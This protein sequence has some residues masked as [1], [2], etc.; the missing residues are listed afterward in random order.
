MSC[1]LSEVDT[2]S[3]LQECRARLREAEHAGRADKLHLARQ[4][5]VLIRLQEDADIQRRRQAEMAREVRGGTQRNNIFII[6]W[7]QVREAGIKL[8]NMEGKLKDERLLARIAAAESS[9]L[10]AALRQQIAAAEV[11]SQEQ[12][13]RDNLGSL[14]LELAGDEEEEAGAEHL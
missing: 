5:A 2:M 9:Q 12:R 13:A 1:R 4:D 8:A 7:G 14:E 10:V 6:F 11:S 3:R